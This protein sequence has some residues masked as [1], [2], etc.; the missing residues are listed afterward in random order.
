MAFA[1]GIGA[2][3]RLSDLPVSSPD[4]SDAARLF[5]ESNSRFLLEVPVKT[6]ELFEKTLQGVP[7][8]RIGETVSKPE[9][10]VYG[11]GGSVVVNA[12][13]SALKESWQKPLRTV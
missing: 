10:T 1:G 11:T 13:L 8:A 12:D 5:S 3:I 4:L 6:A 9:L 7:F 2:T